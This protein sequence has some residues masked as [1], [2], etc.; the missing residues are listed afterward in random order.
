MAARP[1]ASGI[2]RD[3]PRL[4]STRIFSRSGFIS[5]TL[6]A[7]ARASSAVAPLI[8]GPATNTFARSVALLFSFLSTK[9]AS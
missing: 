3:V 9:P 1:A 8:T 6:T 4:S 5:A 7:I 2:L